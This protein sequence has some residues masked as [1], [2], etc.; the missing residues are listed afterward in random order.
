HRAESRPAVGG[1]VFSNFSKQANRRDMPIASLNG[2][3]L[4]Y[5]VTGSG[6]L[7]LLVMGSGSPGRVWRSYQV[8]ALVAAGFRVATMD[9]RGIAPS[10][11]SASGITMAD[12]VGDTAALIE[13]LGA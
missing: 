3:Q 8:P 12:L 5:D 2:I 1:K 11:E 7:V 10:T 13:H 4:N 6:P 9:N